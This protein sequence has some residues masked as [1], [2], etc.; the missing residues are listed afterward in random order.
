M[1]ALT[2][3]CSIESIQVHATT[4]S[5]IP[6][7]SIT[8]GSVGSETCVAAAHKACTI[9]NKR[10]AP[11]KEIL[12]KERAEAAEKEGKPA[13]TEAPTMA[14]VCAKCVGTLLNGFKVNLSVNANYCPKGSHVDDAEAGEFEQNPAPQGAYLTFGAAV[15]EVEIDVLTG[16][17]RVNRADILYDCGH[18]L[19]PLIDIGQAEGAFI[20]GQGMFLGEETKTAP[21]GETLT[22]GTWEYKPPLAV[23]VPRDF[24]V[25]FLKDSPFVHG[26]KSSKAVGEPP[27]ITAYSLFAAVKAAVKASRVERGLPGFVAMDIP[28][29]CDRVF[30]AC[31]VSTADMVESL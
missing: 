28:A 30:Q 6:N 11:V 5:V 31:E 26:V 13:P 7:M 3:G 9:L 12:L 4:T 14:E 27:L 8:G 17:V 24:R 21:D 25:E 15:S 23:N 22:K 16:D 18:S 1:V 19:N 2:L 29:T 10:M 20:H